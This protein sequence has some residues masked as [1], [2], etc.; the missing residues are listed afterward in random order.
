MNKGN[1]NEMV[2]VW[3]GKTK[4]WGEILETFDNQGIKYKADKKTWSIEVLRKDY[5]NAYAMLCELNELGGFG[6]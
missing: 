5:S 4:V 1:Q 6:W 2:N 3:Y